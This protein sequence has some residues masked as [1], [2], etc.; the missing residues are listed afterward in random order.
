MKNNVSQTIRQLLQYGEQM[1]RKAKIPSARFDAELLLA[2]VIKRDRAALFAHSNEYLQSYNAKRYNYIIK[3]RFMR[4]PIAYILHKKEF[5]GYS[6]YVDSR[7]LIPRPETEEFVEITCTYL[8]RMH[9]PLRILD[10]GTGSGCLG[11]SVALSVPEAILYA[12]DISR[13]ALAVAQKNIRR[14]GLGK[15][16]RLIHTP[17]IPRDSMRYDCI[18]SNPPYLSLAEFRDALSYYPEIKYEPK[19][20]LVAKDQGLF[21]LKEIITALPRALTQRGFAFLEICPQHVRELCCF[22]LKQKKWTA[23]FLPQGVQTKRFLHLISKD[24]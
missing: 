22:I 14:Y 7:V 23:T 2:F 15:R 10:I 18:I 19:S 17:L 20:A 11:I 6:F 9:R 5:Y 12:T 3:R 13:D 8:S 16:V 1:L 4:E 21:E 24:S